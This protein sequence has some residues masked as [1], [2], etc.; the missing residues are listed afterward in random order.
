M[1]PHRVKLIKSYAARMKAINGPAVVHDATVPNDEWKEASDLVVCDVPCTG[2]GLLCTSPDIL[3]GKSDEDVSS[4]AEVQSAIL[5]AAARYVAR[6]GRLAYS[7]C[8]LLTE[9]DEA[10]TDRF[11][12]SHPDFVPL[13]ES[14]GKGREDC[15][16]IRFFPDTDGC[17]GF[18]IAR[19]ERT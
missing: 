9:E 4:L 2:S 12:S 19:Y 15:G 7:T 16:R 10:I 13:T 6:G 8:S 5:S 11:I 14:F 1:H 18:Y 3:L 17:D